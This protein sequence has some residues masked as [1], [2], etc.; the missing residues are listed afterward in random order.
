MSTALCTYKY[1]KYLK[2]INI[3]PSGAIAIGANFT[4]DGFSNRPI[5]VITHAHADHILGLEDSLKYSRY[6]VATPIT[7]DLVVALGY[8]SRDLLPALRHKSL[9]LGY[10]Q[11]FSFNGE[12]LEFYNS[13]HIPGSAQ[14]LIKLRDQ[15]I[16][17]G[18]TG[19]FKLTANTEIM[20]G[21]NVLITEATYGN[22]LQTRSFKESIPEILVDLVLE[23][24]TKYKRVYIYAYH[25]KVQEVMNI[26]RSSGVEVPFV[27]P[28][29]IYQATK[30]LE[31]KYGF[32]Y[33]QYYRENGKMSR[34]SDRLIVFKHFNAA[35][36]RKLDGSS[37]HIV[38]TGR[39]AQEPFM[40][41]DDH[42]YVVSLSGHAD[43]ADI[44]KYVNLVNPELVVI[45]GS[46][47]HEAEMLKRFLLEHG[48]CAI[49]LP[50]GNFT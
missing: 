42:T 26:L 38:L 47:S 48:F 6:I 34:L 45:D 41:V 9:P 21:V 1:E 36:D 20:H 31:E 39:F 15:G 25:G 24:L 35:K 44:V 40:K 18:Y 7:L 13:D 3:L 16:L 43:F 46:R 10:H 22:P 5:R 12:E 2:Y 14:V 4:I 32:N 11:S 27:L 19:D 50:G 37:L 33:G 8:I 17:V 28:E 49:V 30:L 29:K 23:G